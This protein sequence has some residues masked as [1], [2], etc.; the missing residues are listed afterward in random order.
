MA[1]NLLLTIYSVSIHFLDSWPQILPHENSERSILRHFWANFAGK[2]LKIGHFAGK[3]W[4]SLPV[5]KHIRIFRF[6][7]RWGCTV[8]FVHKLFTDQFM[9][10]LP[11]GWI[12]RQSKYAVLLLLCL[13]SFNLLF[14]FRINTTSTLAIFASDRFCFFPWNFKMIPLEWKKSTQT[15]YSNAECK[16]L[17]LNMFQPIF[18]Y[19]K[20]CIKMSFC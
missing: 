20:I 5:E 9:Q 16:R 13:E 8:F 2:T 6:F 15:R 11:I 18:Q 14:I 17:N 7:A 3:F 10:M 19:L 1:Q 12:P 4:E